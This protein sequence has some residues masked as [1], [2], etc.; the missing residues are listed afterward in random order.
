MSKALI[1]R[2]RTG[3]ELER[4]EEAVLPVTESGCWLWLG[5]IDKDSYG[6]FWFEGKKYRAHRRL[7]EL[8]T[9]NEI[10]KQMLACHKCDNPMC[11]NPSHIFIGTCKANLVDARD[12]GRHFVGSKNGRSKLSEDEALFILTCGLST[13]FLMDNFNV[14][15]ATINMIKRG[16]TWRHLC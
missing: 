5:N 7:Y 14:S 6:V 9:G 10:D 15:K 8:T 12:K 1:N 13:S 2:I 16:R 11:V 4:M 3:T